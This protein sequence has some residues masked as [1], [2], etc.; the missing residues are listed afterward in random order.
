MD[1]SRVATNLN[2]GDV[3]H[4]NLDGALASIAAIVAADIRAHSILR[5][6]WNGRTS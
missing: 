3:V 2:L 6:S 1:T 5:E 4:I